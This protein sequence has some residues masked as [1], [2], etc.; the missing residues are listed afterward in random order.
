MKCYSKR[1]ACLLSDNA[2]RKKWLLEQ[3]KNIYSLFGSHLFPACACE[4][5]SASKQ[6]CEL[7]NCFYRKP[8][9]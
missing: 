2:T 5:A 7:I 1:F 9:G 3:N 8:S 4:I 6:P